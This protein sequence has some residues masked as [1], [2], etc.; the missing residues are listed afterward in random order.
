MGFLIEEHAM[1]ERKVIENGI[2]ADTETVSVAARK[3]W[4]SVRRWW[5][6]EER[7]W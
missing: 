3:M 5:A 4:R 2:T 1:N 6:Q 7:P